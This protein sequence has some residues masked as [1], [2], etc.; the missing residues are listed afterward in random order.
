MTT[1]KRECS[2][3]SLELGI[4]WNRPI[5]PQSGNRNLKILTRGELPFAYCVLH[6]FSNQVLPEHLYVDPNASS[7][8]PLWCQNLMLLTLNSWFLKPSQL[9]FTW[10]LLLVKWQ[11]LSSNE[12][13][14]NSCIILKFPLSHPASNPSS[15]SFG[16]FLSK[17][18]PNPINY[19][20]VHGLLPSL[21]IIMTV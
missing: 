2:V 15:K 21:R 4:L 12:W 14:Q 1:L 10:F 9:N 18:I 8:S 16:L 6:G 7:G 13:A 3:L 11:H 19:N 5:E 17:Y 20:Q